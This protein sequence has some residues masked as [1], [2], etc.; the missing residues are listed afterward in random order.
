VALA[1][2]V[3]AVSAS[4]PPEIGDIRLLVPDADW[5]VALSRAARLDPTR[6]LR[7]D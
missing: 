6:A 7:H 2:I 3:N 5:R 4:W 1:A